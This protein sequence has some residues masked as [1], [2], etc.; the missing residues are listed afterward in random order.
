MVKSVIEVE[1]DLWG[2]LKT[3]RRLDK[4]LMW[5]VLINLFITFYTVY[6]ENY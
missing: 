2:I 4:Q 1:T 6:S 3:K 5:K